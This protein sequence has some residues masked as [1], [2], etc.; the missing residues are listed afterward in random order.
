M[1]FAF[2]ELYRKVPEIDRCYQSFVGHDNDNVLVGLP[3]YMHG[4]CYGGSKNEK[5]NNSTIVVIIK[6]I[7]KVTT[8]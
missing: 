2:I 5:I 3:G 6:N 8:S 1:F 4:H 7:Q